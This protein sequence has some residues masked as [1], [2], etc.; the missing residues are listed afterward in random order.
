MT[1]CG[2]SQSDGTRGAGFWTRL[3][4]VNTLAGVTVAVMLTASGSRASFLSELASS[5]IFSHTIGGLAGLVVPLVGRR[6][7]WD[8]VRW[9][10]LVLAATLLAAAAV[11]C[12]VA[13][14]LAVGVGLVP[15]S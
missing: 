9:A 4:A 5:L 3:A 15:G 2:T 13:T 10:W 1:A 7:E 6:L 12:T 8:R 11:G 14:F